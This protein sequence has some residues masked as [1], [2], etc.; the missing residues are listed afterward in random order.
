MVNGRL[1]WVTIFMTLVSLAVYGG[2]VSMPARA[3]HA[4]RFVIVAPASWLLLA[5]V[6]GVS[7]VMERRMFYPAEKKEKHT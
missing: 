7:A 2:V 4:A 1:R 3:A 6:I 5:I